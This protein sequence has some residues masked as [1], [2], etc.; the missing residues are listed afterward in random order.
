MIPGL[1]QKNTDDFVRTF[2]FSGPGSLDAE[3]Y[4]IRAFYDCNFPEITRG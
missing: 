2:F 1:K 4:V 3:K